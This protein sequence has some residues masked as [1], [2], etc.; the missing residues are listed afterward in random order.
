[1]TYRLFNPCNPCCDD[2]VTPPAASGVC[3]YQGEY[4]NTTGLEIYPNWHDGVS[5][6]RVSGDNRGIESLA[7]FYPSS[8]EVNTA[9]FR[10]FVNDSFGDLSAS[11]VDIYYL[12]AEFSPGG[13]VI[14]TID[15]GI[16]NTVVPTL[17]NSTVSLTTTIA[18]IFTDDYNEYRAEV[19]I[20]STTYV[21]LYAD[22]ELVVFLAPVVPFSTAA[23][24]LAVIVESVHTSVGGGGELVNEQDDDVFLRWSSSGGGTFS[25][26]TSAFDWP[27]GA[28]VDFYE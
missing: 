21:P 7:G 18:P 19:E 14:N 4:P 26:S 27:I 25:L 12:T 28:C 8:L 24:P 17:L 13:L 20:P 11:S 22:G 1:M 15:S 23:S 9:K 16:I 3:W 5:A 6:W 10:F 2:G